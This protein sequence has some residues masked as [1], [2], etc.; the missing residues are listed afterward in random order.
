MDSSV[1]NDHSVHMFWRIQLFF[2]QAD[3]NTCQG[4]LPCT[5]GQCHSMSMVTTWHLQKHTAE[6]GNLW[7]CGHDAIGLA[8]KV[9]G[10]RGTGKRGV[11]ACDTITEIQHDPT[12]WAIPW[13]L[14]NLLQ[15]ERK[16]PSMRHDCRLSLRKQVYSDTDNISA[17][18]F[19]KFLPSCFQQAEFKVHSS[20]KL[21]RLKCGW[22][23]ATYLGWRM[24]CITRRFTETL[25]TFFIVAW[26]AVT[27]GPCV[28]TC[29]TCGGWLFQS[30]LKQETAHG[31]CPSGL[32]TRPTFGHIFR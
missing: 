14:K 25:P 4:F 27:H 20:V 11:A 26:N 28:G 32:D 24:A 5:L 31:C 29:G 22:A 3:M 9:Q 1:V 30:L 15:I 13:R 23:P 21:F 7:K 2:F 17:L 18:H 8:Q 12:L 6:L 19:S 10:V 16:Y